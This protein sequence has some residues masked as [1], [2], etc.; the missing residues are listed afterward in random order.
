MAGPMLI[1]PL[2]A[3]QGIWAAWSVAW[4][5]IASI[6]LLLVLIFETGPG[7]KVQQKIGPIDLGP[8]WVAAWDHGNRSFDTVNLQYVTDVQVEQLMLMLFGVAMFATGLAIAPLYQKDES[9]A[10]EPPAAV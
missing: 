7:V 2:Q 1:K 3:N 5:G 10:G 8:T 9:A 6:C 4:T